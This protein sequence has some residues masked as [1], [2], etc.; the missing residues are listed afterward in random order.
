MGQADSGLPDLELLMI[1]HQLSSPISL[2]LNVVLQ[3]F[4]VLPVC[5]R[6]SLSEFST[7]LE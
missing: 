5:L 7:V 4:V 1:V 3:W 6:L 2:Q